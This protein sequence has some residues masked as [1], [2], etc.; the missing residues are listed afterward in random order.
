MENT[1]KLAT[2]VPKFIAVN[3]PLKTSGLS[4]ERWS[5]NVTPLA[6]RVMGPKMLAPKPTLVAAA[7]T[8]TVA[9][10]PPTQS[11]FSTKV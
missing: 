2:N 6:P 7:F 3:E 4:V 9:L 10:F 8:T 1:V 5:S 11:L